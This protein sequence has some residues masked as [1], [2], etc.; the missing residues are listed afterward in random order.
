MRR[1]RHRESS[2]FWL[3]LSWVFL[4]NAV[5]RQFS[6]VF[7]KISEHLSIVSGVLRSFCG[8]FVRN[9]PKENLE[10]NSLTTELFKLVFEKS[11]FKLIY[12]THAERKNKN[13]RKEVTLKKNVGYFF[14]PQDLFFLLSQCIHKQVL[15]DI[16][17]HYIFKPL[18]ENAWLKQN[19]NIL[20]KSIF[21]W[22]NAKRCRKQLSWQWKWIFSE[23][24]FIVILRLLLM[25]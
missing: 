7:C 3:I 11:L 20:V 6:H 17:E 14:F 10:P 15:R 22:P 8:D 4:I 2:Y 13:K 16:L 24:V 12:K 19:V 1:V 18:K 23:F 21:Y 5:C 9:S 25:L